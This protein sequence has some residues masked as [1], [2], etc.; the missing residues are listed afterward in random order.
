MDKSKA[1]GGTRPAGSVFGLKEKQ[2][3][4]I[5]DLLHSSLIIET[6]LNFAAT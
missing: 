5:I 1:S 3:Q 2:V 6:G 4:Q